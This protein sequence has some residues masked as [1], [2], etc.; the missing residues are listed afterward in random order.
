MGIYLQWMCRFH[1]HRCFAFSL[2]QR[3]PAHNFN[4]LDCCRT[5][6]V[7]YCQHPCAVLATGGF[8]GGTHRNLNLIADLFTCGGGGDGDLPNFA[9][10]LENLLLAPPTSPARP[11]SSPRRLSERRGKKTARSNRG[12]SSRF[13][14]SFPQ[15]KCICLCE[16]SDSL[17][18]ESSNPSST[19]R[20]PFPRTIP[21]T[22][23]DS[24]SKKRRMSDDPDTVPHPPFSL[25]ATDSHL[26]TCCARRSAL[27]GSRN[28]PT[29]LPPLQPL[30][31]RS[32]THNYR[33]S[34]HNNRSHSDHTRIAEEQH[35]RF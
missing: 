24:D 1:K 19:R 28:Y 3:P 14:S 13:T 21:I 17:R 34:N 29:L 18:C 20:C 25:C 9:G 22:D 4:V 33:R 10:S 26:L 8:H 35:P 2:C 6:A 30:P 7:C 16:S 23:I 5:S 12:L 27:N 32:R 31:N 11:L 15:A